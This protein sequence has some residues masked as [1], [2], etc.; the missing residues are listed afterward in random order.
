MRVVLTETATGSGISFFCCSTTDSVSICSCMRC[1]CALFCTC[2][3]RSSFVTPICSYNRWL[4]TSL[5]NVAILLFIW[6][7]IKRKQTQKIN[8]RYTNGTWSAVANRNVAHPNGKESRDYH[9]CLSDS[10]HRLPSI[11]QCFGWCRRKVPLFFH[12]S[13]RPRTF[14]PKMHAIDVK[15]SPFRCSIGWYPFCK[16][17]I[18]RNNVEINHKSHRSTRRNE[19]QCN[20]LC[21]ISI[22]FAAHTYRTDRLA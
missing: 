10:Y 1:T 11:Y 16:R 12:W 20:P 17:K 6:K 13:E 3:S 2:A 15:I 22:M 8:L 19:W 9:F 21:M 7:R 4:C 18:G 14:D 5:M